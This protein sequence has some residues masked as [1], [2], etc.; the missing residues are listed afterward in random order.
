M[1]ASEPHAV[2]SGW[3]GYLQRKEGIVMKLIWNELLHE[4]FRCGR[5]CAHRAEQKAAGDV[6]PSVLRM[7]HSGALL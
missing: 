1:Q 7:R 4:N 5:M 2:E 3:A 6:L